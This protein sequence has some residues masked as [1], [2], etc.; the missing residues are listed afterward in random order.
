VNLSPPGQP[1]SQPGTL[2]V[3]SEHGPSKIAAPK[4]PYLDSADGA[5]LEMITIERARELEARGTARVTLRRGKPY[6]AIRILKPFSTST[7]S[8]GRTVDAG[9]HN[10]R[11]CNGFLRVL[12][13]IKSEVRK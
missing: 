6:R 3:N 10:R 11:V 5:R 13:P 7:F 2:P 4:I 9:Q 8:R 12:A 1:A